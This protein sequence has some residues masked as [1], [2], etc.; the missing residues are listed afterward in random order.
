ME[1]K[2]NQIAGIN[3][4]QPPTSYAIFSYIVF[5]QAKQ[6]NGKE[7]LSK[8]STIGRGSKQFGPPSP[9]EVCMIFPWDVSNPFMGK[10]ETRMS[11]E[12]DEILWTP[13]NTTRE[14]K[15]RAEKV[16]P[17]SIIWII[18]LSS[19]SQNSKP[20]LIVT[21]YVCVK[22]QSRFSHTHILSLS[23]SLSLYRR[24]VLCKNK[25]K[26]FHQQIS[27]S[28]VSPVS[29]SFLRD[30]KERRANLIRSWRWLSWLFNQF[31]CA[32]IV[33]HCSLGEMVYGVAKMY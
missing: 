8:T 30:R 6:K 27:A 13:S 20:F 24:F 17:G 32:F 23:L 7:N 25:S 2:G 15:T 28:M 21:Y 22:P 14:Q 31:S 4:V 19:C 10:E 12:G 16:R 18:S 29:A 11:E 1:E 3:F 9:Y 26:A 5:M 33:R